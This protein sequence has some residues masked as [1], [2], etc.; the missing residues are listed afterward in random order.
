MGLLIGRS[1]FHA[2]IYPHGCECWVVCPGR[3]CV[4]DG[5][6]SVIAALLFGYIDYEKLKASIFFLK[7]MPI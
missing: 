4:G 2:G 3:S 7:S 1:Q 6:N 5:T